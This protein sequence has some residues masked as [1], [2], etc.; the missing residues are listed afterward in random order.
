MLESC[1]RPGVSATLTTALLAVCGLALVTASFLLDVGVVALRN[2]PFHRRPRW[3][4]RPMWRFVAAPSRW[5]LLIAGLALAAAA[6]PWFAVALA[7]IWIAARARRAWARSPRHQIAIL[8]DAYVSLCKSDPGAPREELLTA[9]I[10]SRHPRWD[11]DLIARMIADH[12]RVDD[13]F[14]A[15][16]RLERQMSG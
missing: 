2:L 10:R 8:K 7:L 12:P 1:G 6:S 15:L 5:P 13:L 4:H 9:V 16:V 11:T 14:A 3:A